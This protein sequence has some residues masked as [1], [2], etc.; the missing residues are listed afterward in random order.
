MSTYHLSTNSI[1]SV[2]TEFDHCA[3]LL[4]WHGTRKG[5]RS[6]GLSSC[7]G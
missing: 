6:L 5:T 4:S 2:A 3:A 1:V 7:C